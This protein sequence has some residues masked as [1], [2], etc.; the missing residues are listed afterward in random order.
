M[1]VLEDGRHS[2]ISVQPWGKFDALTGTAYSLLF[3]LI[4]SGAVAAVLWDRFL[5][6]S[7]K[8][9]ITA[10]LQMGEEQARSLV[11][12]LAACH[13]VGKLTPHFQ[14][15]EPVARL[16]LG[17]E[18]LADM[19]PVTPVSHARASMH[20]GVNLLHGLGFTREGNDSPAVRAAQCLGGHHGRYLQ[21]DLHRAA[22][23]RRVEANL[24]GPSWRD[25][26]YRYVRLLWHLF[27]VPK[28]PRCFSAEAAVLITGLIMLADRLSSQRRFWLPNADTPSSGAN[29]H[30]SRAR[31][32]ASDEV[33]RSHLTRFDLDRIPFAAA[34]RGVQTPNAMQASVLEAMPELVRQ[35]GSGIAVV[36]DATGSGKT[37]TG[38]ELARIF[39]EHCGTQGVM[40]L[41]PATAAADQAYDILDRYVRAHQPEHAP[42][43]LVHSHSWLNPAY[44][45][46]ALSA[47]S[48]DSVLDGPGD[49]SLGVDAAA[50]GD[51]EETEHGPGPAGPDAW[52]RGWDSAL[53][54]QYTVA[55]VDQ[56][57][58][59]VLPVRHSPLRLLAMSG[60][61]VIVDE[62]HAL[63]P[64]SQ[65]QLQ[66]LL[67]WLGALGTPVVLLSATLPASTQSGL[68]RSYL[69]GA[70]RTPP[71][72][73]VSAP[74]YPGCTLTD[75][76]TGLTHH[77]SDTAR[78]AHTAAQR[79]TVRLAVRDVTYRQLEHADR[80]VGERER[81]EAVADLLRP[82]TEGGGCAAVVCAT[83]A[84]A[85]DTYTHLSRSW[86]GPP[87]DLL[88]VHARLPGYRRERLLSALRRRLGR[89]GP[90]PQRLV[91]VTT[92]LLDMSLD[93][94]VDVM[95]SD[96]ASM[97]RLLQ[98]LGR[99]ARFAGLWKDAHRPRWWQPG[100]EPCMTV[101][102]P[103]GDRGGTALPPGWNSIEPGFTLHATAELLHT[104]K[105]STLTIPDDI[106]QLV[107][108]IHGKDSRFGAETDRLARM[109]AT[110]QS[111]TLRDEHLSAIQLVPPSRRVSSM[112]D[113]HRQHLTTAHAATRLGTMP[114]RLLPC[115]RL[116]G[117]NL[118][119]DPAGRL[120]L[121]D[122]EHLSTRAIR[123]I[124]EHTLPVPA[125]WVARAP[126]DSLPP[127]TWAKHPLLVGTVLLPT[128]PDHPLDGQRFGRHHLRMDDTLG[129]THRIDQQR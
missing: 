54:A 18:L 50:G 22:S 80:T 60:K 6:P 55:T 70:G 109:L 93:I 72:G 79:R 90:R 122:G 8:A 123:S 104:L 108:L 125:A 81:L 30:Y 28:P 129:L 1:G 88:L 15:C 44:T 103:V 76:A 86:P 16:R 31:R 87:A 51:D 48:E 29:E 111:Q 114:R 65:L 118:S 40:W 127:A 23:A 7:Q 34:H 69:S 89:S 61:T 2:G 98:R 105:S 43:T 49:D 12:F 24:G 63:T 47:G 62:A 53:L 10:G 37:V 112:A 73:T 101:L 124:L 57:Q 119:L 17:D 100:H 38:L 9:A 26:R 78:T 92:S 52:L 3:H 96:L 126:L 94:D 20:I 85:Q 4:D 99:L 33:E 58:M 106:Q 113:L 110:Q 68:I 71:D 116:P 42:V 46:R 91:V 84:D 27:D 102:N 56:A 67:N 5:T 83:V 117:N 64:F 36:T 77:M 14:C 95:V 74:V 21:M 59:A 115:Y 39:N 32:Q 97:A 120:P 41:L 35:Q 19:G 82:V 25:L 13:D 107:E 121:P 45:D 11:A 66:R 128:D 75:A